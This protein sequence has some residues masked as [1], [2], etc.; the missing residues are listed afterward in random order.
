MSGS[1][2]GIA[3][4]QQIPLSSPFQPGQSDQARAREER[5][6]EPQR[7][8]P[9]GTA[10]GETEETETRRNREDFGQSRAVSS[11]SEDDSQARRGSIVDITV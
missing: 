6:V 2:S 10:S 5:E 3:G 7:I 9:T 8:Q 11:R 4:Q 1:L